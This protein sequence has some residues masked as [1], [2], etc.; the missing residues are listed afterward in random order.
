MDNGLAAY[1]SLAKQ[2][3][4]SFP[5]YP[6]RASLRDRFSAEADRVIADYGK[7]VRVRP[8]TRAIGDVRKPR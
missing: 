8:C 1:N 6:A 5:L 2:S 4:F 7:P 3:L